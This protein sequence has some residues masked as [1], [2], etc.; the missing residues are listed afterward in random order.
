L[1]DPGADG[2]LG[3]DT[4]PYGKTVTVGTTVGELSFDTDQLPVDPAVNV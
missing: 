2:Y 1:W 3:R 4:I